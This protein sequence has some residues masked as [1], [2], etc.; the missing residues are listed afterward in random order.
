VL[1]NNLANLPETPPQPITAYDWQF[2]QLP[3]RSLV[4]ETLYFRCSSDDAAAY[5][6]SFRLAEDRLFR[7]LE[8]AMR[9][10]QE[11]GL[12]TLVFNFLPPQHNPMGR[13]LPRYD[14]RNMAYFVE[15]LNESLARKL[16]SFP[17][18][19]LLDF[20][21][22]V[23][24]FG[25]KYLQE[26]VIGMLN[27]GVFLAANYSYQDQGRLHTPTQV[28]RLDRAKRN[29][30]W[31][32]VW[33]ESLAMFRTTRQADAVKLVI[34]DL[35]D[36][37]W[38]GV[39]AESG[40]I[41]KQT[42]EGW[43]LGLVEALL[44]LKRRGIVLAI[45]SKN[46]ESRIRALWRQIWHGRIELSDFAVVKINW[47]PKVQNVGE[48]MRLVNVLPRST[49]FIDDNP[50]E[51]AAVQAAFPDIR[52]LGEELYEIRRILLWSAETQVASL[53]S[54]SAQ[55]TQMIQAQAAREEARSQMSREE[56]LASLE[57][58]VE[59]VEIRSLDDAR[60][61]RA[62]EL[63]NKTNQFNTTGRRWTVEELQALFQGG[64]VL[65]AFEV[66]DR[67]TAY[68]L[69]GCV[70]V[71]RSVMQQFVMSCRVIGLDVE[72]TVMDEILQRLRGQGAT[73]V[74]ACFTATDANF[75]CRDLFARCGFDG[76]DGQWTKSLQPQPLPA[77]A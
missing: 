63:I 34:V 39:V 40:Q 13:L 60:F 22:I 53:S 9:W 61:R 41:E 18:A 73:E 35:D 26:D 50:V 47:Q 17:N 15:R 75:P 74:T 4:P 25:R 5:E 57:L 20:D 24:G 64:G 1:T 52:T 8:A 21:Q 66:H 51:R 49:V 69:V 28:P 10:N 43:P 67:F 42:T 30:V 62:H 11:H 33:N 32:A 37:L 58:Q 56:F 14:L 38:R 54:E 3:L 70:M 23:A 55:R 36:T 76:Q 19:Y 7:L 72:L 44:Y 29:E 46:E 59:L 6:K 77:T 65:Y 68:G 12:L 16:E 27:H 71:V 45:A 31:S 48:I 2:I